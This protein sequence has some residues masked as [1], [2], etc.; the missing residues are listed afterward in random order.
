LYLFA[1]SLLWHK[2]A[3]AAGAW[4]MIHGLH[5]ANQV[6]RAIASAL[7]FK[8]RTP[9]EKGAAQARRVPSSSR[10]RS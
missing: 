7:L 3:D 4:E 9:R 10:C 2:Q 8:R 6:T 1:C 5:S